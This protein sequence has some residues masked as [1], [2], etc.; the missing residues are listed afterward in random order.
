LCFF[1]SW[2]LIIEDQKTVQTLTA[3]ILNEQTNQQLMPNNSTDGSLAYFAQSSRG[4]SQLPNGRGSFNSRGGSNGRGGVSSNARAETNPPLDK[5]PRLRCEHCFSTTGREL[6]HPTVECNKLKRKILEDAQ[7]QTTS[8]RD[9]AN[10]ATAT[11]T[12][13]RIDFGY[14]AFLGNANHRDASVWIADCGAK[15]TRD[16]PKVRSQQ[17]CER[18]HWQLDH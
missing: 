14:P 11:I 17:L 12:N 6:N 1:S 4:K 15:K 10:I 13:P 2:E 5:R 8:R 7:T 18:P 3:K 9:T 16:Q